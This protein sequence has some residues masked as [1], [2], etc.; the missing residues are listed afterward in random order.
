MSTRTNLFGP[1]KRKS[2]TTTE[3]FDWDPSKKEWTPTNKT[4]KTEEYDVDL[5]DP[6]NIPA[7]MSPISTPPY[8]PYAPYSPYTVTWQ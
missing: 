5:P 4:T 1:Q 7:P 6:T 2:V 3:H 8:S